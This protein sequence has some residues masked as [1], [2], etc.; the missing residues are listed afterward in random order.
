MAGFAAAIGGAGNALQNY[1]EQMRPILE[2]QRETLAQQI[3]NAAQTES[4]PQ[5]RSA[6][7][8]HQ[9]DLMAGKPLGKITKD[10]ATTMQKR[11]ADAQALA[12]GHQA[13]AQMIG[14]PQQQ[15]APPPAPA[16][17]GQ[18]PGT[19]ANAQLVPSIASS[20]SEQPLTQQIGQAPAA[21]APGSPVQPQ[22]QTQPGPT[23]AALNGTQ[24]TTSVVPPVA[25]TGTLPMGIPQPVAQAD[26]VNKYLTD[27]RWMAPANRQIMQSAMND[28]LQH[29]EQLRLVQEQMQTKMAYASNAIHQ[30]QA[31]GTWDQLPPITRAQYLAEASGMQ[32]APMAAQMMLPHDIAPSVRGEDIPPGV[33]IVGT[34]DAPKS[35]SLYRLQY[36]P[37]EGRMVAVP[38]A[39]QVGI[40]QTPNG[41]VATFNRQNPNAGITPVSGSS[42]A[43][44]NRL[45]NQG[46]DIAGHPIMG[47]AGDILR[48]LAS[49]NVFAGA[50]V[51][52]TF[53][54]RV[55]Q[56]SQLRSISTTDEQGNPITQLV[57]VTTTTVSQRGT[58]AGASAPTPSTAVPSSA[59]RTFAKPFSP[60]QQLKNTQQLGQY[61]LA[62]GRVQNVRNHLDLLNGLIDAGKLNLQMDPNQGILM[63]TIN[64]NVPMT[65]EEEE[66]IGDFQ[67]MREDINLLRGPMGATGFRG[68]EAFA[69]LQ[70]QRGQLL[71]RPGITAHVLDN[72]LN[73]L[74]VQR[75]ALYN[76]IH[77]KPIAGPVQ[78]VGGSKPD[79]NDLRK[80]YN[81]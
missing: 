25:A 60:E 32:A 74:K 53:I 21:Q 55:S 42:A 62:M 9:A 7:L 77:G 41:E 37:M 66:F 64:R 45:V 39:P 33:T 28:E 12:Q 75:D 8:Q 81:Y 63:A 14:K 47:R 40:T 15:A 49:G 24:A 29:N 61:D 4:D 35:G 70:S 57:P 48:D 5:T 34:S 80:K 73:A 26:I 44:A 23:I 50:G 54:P 38:L 72:T 71:A 2:R 11:I 56:G 10:F 18:T 3:G 1:S 31:N 51:N 58:R 30:M 16:A 76:A 19:P 79:V 65:K 6:L 52:P 68:P 78:P 46:V 36:V 27:P 59:N 17:P 43:G 69:A 20:T 22:E 13:I 67:T